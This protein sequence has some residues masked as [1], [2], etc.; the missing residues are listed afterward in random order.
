MFLISNLSVSG[1]EGV[2]PLKVKGKIEVE[3]AGKKVLKGGYAYPAR[4]LAKPWERVV[5]H[6]ESKII[7][8]FR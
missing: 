4:E 5:S 1:S 7:K 8:K 3:G 2:S 6:S